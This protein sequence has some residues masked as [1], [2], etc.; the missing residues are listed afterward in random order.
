MFHFVFQ[1]PASLYGSL[2]QNGLEMHQTSNQN[3]AQSANVFEE[4][5]KNGLYCQMLTN[6][7]GQPQGDHLQGG[8]HS[9]KIDGVAPMGAEHPRCK[10][11]TSPNQ[12]NPAKLP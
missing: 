7:T 10:Y 3:Y 5:M 1:F 6:N 9:G 8:Q 4:N 11:T 2:S 12:P